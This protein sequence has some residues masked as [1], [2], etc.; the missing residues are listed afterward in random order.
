MKTDLCLG[1]GAA[2]VFGSQQWSPCMSTLGDVCSL[3]HIQKDQ[4]R[5]ICFSKWRVS[6]SNFLIEICENDQHLDCL[7]FFL[8]RMS[9]SHEW[10][11]RLLLWFFAVLSSGIARPIWKCVLVWN[12]SV[13]F[14]FPRCALSTWL[15]PKCNW[16]QLGRPTTN[17]SNETCD[18]N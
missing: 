1:L 16:T 4:R 11:N 15:R 6:N 13:Y 18:V 2:S 5:W 8:M 7:S 3:L 10:K 9:T 12:L 17:Q 14:R